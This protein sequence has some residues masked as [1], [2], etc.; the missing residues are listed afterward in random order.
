MEIDYLDVFFRVRMPENGHPEVF[1]VF[2]FTGGAVDR[3]GSTWQP[4]VGRHSVRGPRRR[5]A[6]CM[7]LR[8]TWQPLVGRRSMSGPR[9]GAEGAVDRNGTRGGSG[10]AGSRA[11]GACNAGS[12]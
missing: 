10:L 11:R 9:W 1:C 3:W 2:G 5:A 12:G 4:L 7:D 6:W 8:D